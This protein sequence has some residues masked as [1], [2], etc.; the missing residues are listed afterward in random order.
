M[1][2][3]ISDIPIRKD[4]V[5][6]LKINI[7]SEL[8][9]ELVSCRNDIKWCLLDEDDDFDF[10]M[11]RSFVLLKLKEYIEDPRTFLDWEAKYPDRDI[12]IYKVS[13]EDLDIWLQ[14]D[15]GFIFKFLCIA[16]DCDYDVSQILC[17]DYFGYHFTSIM[18]KVIHRE[19][20]EERADIKEDSNG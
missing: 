3:R 16:E 20:M 19:R 13:D 6:R 11:K 7:L 4:K 2:E 12:I 8:T 14:E 5:D 9:K 17:D 10:L 1:N 18:D 15:Y